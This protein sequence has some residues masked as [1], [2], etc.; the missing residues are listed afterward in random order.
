MDVVAHCTRHTDTAWRAFCLEPNRNI[1]A[2]AVNVS[3]L[4]YHVTNIDTHTELN[5]LVLLVIVSEETA[6][7]LNSHGTAHCSVDA[8]EHD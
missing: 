7:F 8:V 6:L 3:T 1:H 2:V 5:G 4:F